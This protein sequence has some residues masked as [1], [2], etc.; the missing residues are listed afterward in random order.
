[1]KKIFFLSF[2][3][4][5]ASVFSFAQDQRT[6]IDVQ[7]TKAELLAFNDLRSL[8]SAVNKGQDYSKYVIRNFNL[9]TLVSGP[10]STE[11]IVTEMGPGGVWSE[12]QKAMIEKYAKKGVVFTLEKIVMIES[13]QKGT[14]VQPNISIT[15][16]E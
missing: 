11:A 4:L 10:N 7:Y 6:V 1:M 15:I 9:T 2:I 12:K 5:A 8:L 16:K 13:G 3:A 14:I